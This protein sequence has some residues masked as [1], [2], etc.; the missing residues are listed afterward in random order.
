MFAGEASL[1]L[2]LQSL[3]ACLP[4]AQQSNLHFKGSFMRLL[5]WCF[6]RNSEWNFRLEQ[7]ENL[8]K[9][10]VSQV[11]FLRFAQDDSRSG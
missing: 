9:G 1:R 2:D 10:S 8:S 11:E 3:R 5:R 6:P 7:S 4:Q